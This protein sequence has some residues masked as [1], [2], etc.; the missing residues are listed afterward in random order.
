MI[1]VAETGSGKTAAFVLPILQAFMDKPQRLHSLILAPTRILAQ[2][3]AHVVEALGA[4][5][6]VSCTLLIGGIDLVSQAMSLGKKPH[7]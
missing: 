4:A 5:M 2:Q 1:G 6:S 3:T 7:V